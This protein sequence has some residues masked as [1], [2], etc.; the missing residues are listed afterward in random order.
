MTALDQMAED[1]EPI[2]LPIGDA[3]WAGVTRYGGVPHQLVWPIHIM[4]IHDGEARL[5][6]VL[7]P[8][9]EEDLLPLE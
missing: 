9:S 6:A 7:P 1:N 8:P 5:L 2:Y 3:Y 4:D